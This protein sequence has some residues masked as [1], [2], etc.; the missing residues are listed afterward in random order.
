V[1]QQLFRYFASRVSCRA[2]NHVHGFLLSFIAWRAVT[3]WMPVACPRD[4]QNLLRGD[5]SVPHDA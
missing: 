5:F 4:S 2:G 3:D 1:C